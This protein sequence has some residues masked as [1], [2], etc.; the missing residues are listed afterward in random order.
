M[1]GNGPTSGDPRHM[2]VLIASKNSHK[3]DLLAAKLLGL[4]RDDVPTLEAA[5]ERNL[6]TGCVEDLKIHGDFEPCITPDFARVQA[7][8]NLLFR[9]D[10]NSRLHRIRGKII[11]FLLCPRPILIKDTCIGCK[12]CADICPAKAIVMKNKL[13][14]I[15]R[16][17]CI[18]C[19]CCQEFCPKGAMAVHRPPMARMLSK[20]KP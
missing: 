6:L 11:G 4:T 17:T 15:N 1:E 2:G 16:S 12:K 7:Q 18:R 3:L 13:P 19:F 8:S 9:G 20:T 5:F 10:E 14:V